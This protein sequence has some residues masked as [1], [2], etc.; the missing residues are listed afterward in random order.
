M[1]ENHKELDS[2]SGNGITFYFANQEIC[3]KKRMAADNT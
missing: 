2:R 1:T 3:L